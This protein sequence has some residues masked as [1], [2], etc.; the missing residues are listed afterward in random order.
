MYYEMI[1]IY[2]SQDKRHLKNLL[3]PYFI[4]GTLADM[5]NT[6]VSHKKYLPVIRNHLILKN[7]NHIAQ[8]YFKKDKYGVSTISLVKE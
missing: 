6:H 2:S 4:A 1:N 5:S 7:K 3:H 8:L